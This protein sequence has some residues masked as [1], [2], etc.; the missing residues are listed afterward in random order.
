MRVQNNF[1]EKK[2]ETHGVNNNPSTTSNGC[3]NLQKKAESERTRKAE[4]YDCAQ[5]NLTSPK[6]AIW[7]FIFA[8]Y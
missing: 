7:L 5:S 1:T 8:F 4:K 6:S 3:I 2:N